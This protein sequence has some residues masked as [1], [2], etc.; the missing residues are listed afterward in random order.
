VLSSSSIEVLKIISTTPLAAM[1]PEATS[2][3][4]EEERRDPP[5]SPEIKS[6]PAE[7]SR[8]KPADD[9]IPDSG[10]VNEVEAQ[11]ATKAGCWSPCSLNEEILATMEHKGFIAG[12]AI[13]RWWVENNAVMPAPLEEVVMLKYHVDRGLSLPPPR[14]FTGMLAYYKLQLHHNPLNSFTIIVGFVAFCEG[15]LG[16]QHRGDLFRLYINIR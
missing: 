6:S 12:R 10:S 3:R 2:S 4:Y 5:Q 1:E 13:S 15:Y 16:V 9:A 11:P 14:F 7:P 8:S